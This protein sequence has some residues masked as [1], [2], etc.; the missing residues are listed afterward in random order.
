M[1]SKAN[2][3]E[4]I[5]RLYRDRWHVE[6]DLRNIKTSLGMEQLS[7]Q[8]PAMAE[9]K[10]WV[11][12]LAYNLIRLMMAHAALLA[13]LLAPSVKLQAYG[14]ILARLG[15]SRLSRQHRPPQIFVL[16]AQQ[17]VGNRPNIE[18][19]AI[20]RRQ[21]AY[22]LLTQPRSVARDNVRKNGHPKSLRA[23]L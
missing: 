23:L 9:G 8:T 13:W 4:A 6:L 12:L 22:P 21:K 16:I 2:N 14:A 18:P 19:R 11:Y 15:A 10:I 17:T 3:Q 1:L 20:K 5:K 7:C